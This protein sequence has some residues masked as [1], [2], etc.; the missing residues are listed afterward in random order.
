MAPQ[1]LARLMS[2]AKQTM[3]LPDAF[4]HAPVDDDVRPYDAQVLSG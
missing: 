2:Y 1:P 3:H 4:P